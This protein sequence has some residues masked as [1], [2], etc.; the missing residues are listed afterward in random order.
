MRAILG[1]GK[2]RRTRVFAELQSHY[3]F[4]GLV[5]YSRRNFVVPLLAFASFREL[6]AHLED[7]FTALRMKAM[8]LSELL[9]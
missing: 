2:R 7:A 8:S 6:N 5:G 1:D 9:G 3:L 4:E